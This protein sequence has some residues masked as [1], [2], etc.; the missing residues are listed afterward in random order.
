MRKNVFTAKAM[1]ISALCMLPYAANAQEDLCASIGKSAEALMKGRQ[2]GVALQKSLEGMTNGHDQAAQEMFKAM[3][4]A[5]YEVP[6]YS[7][8]GYKKTAIE[9]FRDDQQLACLKASKTAQ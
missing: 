9:N 8:D 5:E 7:S 4:I 3:V 6:R 2:A 1:L